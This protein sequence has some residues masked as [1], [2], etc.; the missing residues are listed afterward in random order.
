VAVRHTHH[1]YLDT[2]VSEASN[3]SCPLAF[4]HRSALEFEAKR[5][6]ELDR[7]L[8]I[9]NDDAHVVKLECHAL[10]LPMWATE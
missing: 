10:T 2:L 4:D 8:E 7:N 6:E 5:E 3:S 1:G 9:L